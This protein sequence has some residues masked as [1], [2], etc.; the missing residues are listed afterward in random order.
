MLVFSLTAWTI[1]KIKYTSVHRM[2]L[3]TLCP[4]IFRTCINKIIPHLLNKKG[5]PEVSFSD[6]TL[7]CE[8]ELRIKLLDARMTRL[9]D[10]KGI[11]NNPQQGLK[12][13]LLKEKREILRKIGLKRVLR[14]WW[15]LSG[16]GLHFNDG[17]FSSSTIHVYI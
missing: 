5:S 8:R 1:A 3:Y 6:T 11:R 7:F 4:H 15:T 10:V 2:E 9:H 16:Y 13:R 17:A 14:S 12:R